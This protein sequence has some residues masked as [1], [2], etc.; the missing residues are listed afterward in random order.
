MVRVATN[1]LEVKVKVCLQLFHV[2]LEVADL[3]KIIH[4]LDEE[5]S[6]IL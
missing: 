1:F 2:K 5:H 3:G 4:L 6:V